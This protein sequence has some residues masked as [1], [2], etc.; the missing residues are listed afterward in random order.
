MARWRERKGRPMEWG[1]GPLGQDSV[2]P[3]QPDL[4]FREDR[5]LQLGIEGGRW[6]GRGLGRRDLRAAHTKPVAKRKREL[7]GDCGDDVKWPSPGKAR[8]GGGEGEIGA[9]VKRGPPAG[10]GR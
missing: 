1:P 5:V 2:R 6:Q 8:L 9:K 10:R 7:R 4:D 3:P